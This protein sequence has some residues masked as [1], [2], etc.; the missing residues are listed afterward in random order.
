MDPRTPGLLHGIPPPSKVLLIRASR[1]G[2]FVCATPA[3]RA[4][5]GALPGAE[6][7]LVGLPF[8][9]ELVDRSPHLDR[10]IRFPGFPGM[11]EQFFEPRVAVGFFAAMHAEHFDLAVQMHGSGANSNPFALLCGARTTAGFVRPGDQPGCLDAAIPYPATGHAVDRLLALSDFLGA[12]RAGD[13]TEFPI[14]QRDEAAADVLLSEAER[15]LIGLHAGARD[16]VK[17]WNRERFAAVAS[18]LWRQ[19]GGTIVFIGG[20]EERDAS[21]GM[22]K[23]GVPYLDLAGRTSLAVL[24]AIIRRLSVLVTNDSGPAHIGY[25]LGTPTITIFGGTSPL[26][27]G[28]R[29]GPH[30]VVAHHVP[31]RPCELASCPIDYDCLEHVRTE[32]VV[33]AVD[34][35]LR[36]TSPGA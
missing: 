21:K 9:E 28:P 34:D 36:T 26:M 3:F 32:M 2:D 29:G 17:R 33:K 30:R 5:R 35:V 31:C 25:A 27:W 23:T 22:M 19:R 12:P 15:P 13:E 1:I 20:D 8:V 18:E 16:A 24:G 14:W 10:F 7:T 6:I 4:L 11:A